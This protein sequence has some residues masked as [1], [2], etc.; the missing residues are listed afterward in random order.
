MPA[1]HGGNGW[2]LPISKPRSSWTLALPGPKARQRSTRL[3][4]AT[5]PCGPVRSLAQRGS[6]HRRGR[7]HRP[8][9]WRDR[10][11]RVGRHVA[12]EA[13]ALP[14]LLERWAGVYGGVRRG[15]AALV[16]LA[17]A[18]QRL[19]WIHRSSTA[20]AVSCGCTPICCCRPWATGGLWSPL[21]GFARTP[22]RYFAL[23]AAADEPRR[24][25]L[26]GRGNLSEAALI[27]W[28]DYVLDTCLDQGALH[29]LDAAPGRSKP[30]RRLPA[31]RAAQPAQRVRLEALRP[32]HYLFATGIALDAASSNA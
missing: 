18:H 31:L 22:D 26:D 10:E 16:A 15:E 12:P 13:A 32:L 11:V 9:Q 1:W 29:G 6:C 30:H 8:G 14:R 28:I 27:A 7:R 5:G 19:G 17:A 20:M 25:D 2:P 21:R 23:L 3:G 4:P 24:G